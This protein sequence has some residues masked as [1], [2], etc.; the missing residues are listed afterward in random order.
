METRSVL[1][2]ETCTPQSVTNE[3]IADTDFEALGTSG[4]SVVQ[5]QNLAISIRQQILLL[6]RQSGSLGITI[7]EAERLI[8]CHKGHSISPRFAELIKR[9]DRTTCPPG[10]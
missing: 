4:T 8:K 10:H 7:N 6:A 5:S 1:S 2:N 3:G 9:G